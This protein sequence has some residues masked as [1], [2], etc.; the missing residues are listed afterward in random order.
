MSWQMSYDPTAATEAIRRLHLAEE[1]LRHL[2]PHWP[3]IRPGGVLDV[4]GPVRR[5]RI[6]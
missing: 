1:H 5:R 4:D 3:E 2:L 6:R